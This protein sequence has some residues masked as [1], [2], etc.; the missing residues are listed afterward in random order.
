MDRR[1][2]KHLIEITRENLKKYKRKRALADAKIK[3]PMLAGDGS[4]YGETP[5]PQV[6]STAHGHTADNVTLD[7]AVI[8]ASATHGHT[9]DNATV[10]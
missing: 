1:F 7:V 4:A 9:A 3:A 10:T 5:T 2:N 8:V 6:Q